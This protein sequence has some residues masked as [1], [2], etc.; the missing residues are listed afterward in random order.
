MVDLKPDTTRPSE[1]PSYRRILAVTSI[2]GGASALNV[3]I[4]LGRAKIVA[5][6]IGP[7]GM[8]IMGMFMSIT[9]L[10]SALTS[11]GLNY[12]GVRELASVRSSGDLERARSTLLTFRQLSRWLAFGGT[13]ILALL[14]WP[15][16]MLSFGTNEYTLPIAVLSLSVAANVGANYFMAKIQAVGAMT[17]VAASNV[18]GALVGAIGAIVLLLFWRE[19]GIVPA[20]LTGA[21]V[22]CVSNWWHSRNLGLLEPLSGT[23]TSREIRQRLLNLGGLVIVIGLLASATVLALRTLVMRELGADA[24]GYF[25]SAFGL[26]GMYAGYILGAMGTDFLPRLS[27][28]V[29]DNGQINRLVNEQTEVGLLLG[30]PG[31]LGTI[32]LASLVIPFFYSSEFAQ[33]VPVLQLMSIGVFGRLIS[34]PMSFVVIVRNEMRFSLIAECACHVTQLSIVALTCRELGVSATGWASIIGYTVFSLVLYR[35][36]R[37]LTGFVWSPSILRILILGLTAVVAVLLSDWYVSGQWKWLLGGTIWV[38]TSFL[39]LRQLMASADL[40]NIALVRKLTSQL[41]RKLS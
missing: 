2:L 36:L 33:S 1:I 20:L 7:A 15:V 37:R 26:S 31:V 14:A 22:Q 16:S 3:L 18:S 30:L 5:L 40:T 23:R 4:G 21:F 9:G 35:M 39:C 10:A 19:Q 17:R 8:G 13:T 27:A 41:K 38:S 25:Q 24:A 28:V 11:C 6:M 12:S 29:S 32:F 34:W